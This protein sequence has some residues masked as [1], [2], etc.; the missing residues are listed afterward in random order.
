MSIYVKY[1]SRKITDAFFYMKR[2]A[3]KLMQ[4]NMS[5]SGEDVR[6]SVGCYMLPPLAHP[7]ACC[8]APCKRTQHYWMLQSCVRLHTLMHVVAS[9]WELLCKV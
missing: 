5:K 3:F 7:V 4:S 2:L 9:C 6:N 1:S 8:L